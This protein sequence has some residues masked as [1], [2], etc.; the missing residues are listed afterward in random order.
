M[1]GVMGTIIIDLV[2]FNNTLYAHT[3]YEVYQS[4][5]GGGSWKKLWNHGQEAVLNIPTTRLSYESKLIP[6]GNLLYSLSGVGDNLRIFRLST[7]ENMLIPVQGVPVFDRRKLAYEK[8]YKSKNQENLRFGRLKVETAAASRDVF[9]VEWL[10]ELFKW[11]VGDSEWTSTGLVDG[12]HLP[13]DFRKGF[14][15]AVLGETVYVGKREGKL[16]QSLDEGES[17]KDVTPNL[18]LSFTRFNDIAFVGSTL[19]VATDSAVMVS[20][21]G[22]QWY[23]PTDNAGE[24]PIINRFAIDESKVYGI[25]DAGGYR[26]D[27]RMQW[28]QISSEVPN[29]I[30][31]L[32]IA[33]DKVYGATDQV[34]SAKENGLFYISLEENKKNK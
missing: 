27:T 24:R 34:Y 22:E 25:G 7:N 12:S 4:A 17:W 21:T 1:N 16:F 18:P 9:Y 32:A 2:A 5:D 28:E 26:L 14:K 15:L 8:Y 10:G 30:S 29:E 20:Q 11:K 13:N 3:G 6:V 33:N 23:V 19:Y 31:A